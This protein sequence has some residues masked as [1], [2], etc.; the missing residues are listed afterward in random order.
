MEEEG[1]RVAAEPGTTITVFAVFSALGGSLLGSV[2][3]GCLNY[4]L[5]NRALNAAKAQREAD[6]FEVRKALGYSLLFKM[7][8]LI[9]DLVTLGKAIREPMDTAKKAGF[10]GA[11]FQIVM[12]IVPM[13]D[14]VKFSPEEM[15]LVL[16]I[17]AELFNELGPLDEL[18]NS[19]VALCELYGSKRTSVMER[20]EA[21][22]E[23]S[24]GTTMLTEERKNWLAP[25][26]VELNSL[27]E[28]L[29]QRTEQDGKEAWAALDRLHVVLEREF[30]L[31]HKLEPK[32]H[33]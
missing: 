29:L 25:R 5:Q 1:T 14:K 4:W 23:G 6:R 8:R 26:A 2:V 19:T 10:V 20:F 16:S 32:V 13:P 15:A 21:K 17:D 30:K 28:A 24:I 12:P 7:I 18:H 3:G 31:K 22:M 11:P 27:V 33:K 9:S